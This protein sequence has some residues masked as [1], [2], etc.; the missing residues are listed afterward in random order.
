MATLEREDIQGIILSA[1]AHLPCAGYLLFRIDDPARAR[2]W[3]ARI[4]DEIT[5]AVAKQDLY[6]LNLA[7]TYEGLRALGLDATALDTF[8]IPFREGMHSDK[9]SLI[10]G[11]TN[12]NHPSQWKWGNEQ[13]S[14][15]LLLM[16][17]AE[18][19]AAL[20]AQLKQRTDEIEAS[21]ALSMIEFLPAGRQPDSHEHFGYADGIGQPVI[22]ENE[23]HEKKQRARTGHATV[24]K[25]GEFILGYVNEYGIPSVSPVVAAALDPRAQLPEYKVPEDLRFAREDPNQKLH[26]LGYNGSYLV[27]RHLRQNV[28]DFWNFLDEAT[29]DSN[30][31]SDQQA[32]ERLG[33][34]F[35][36]RWPSGAPLVKSPAADDAEFKDENNFGFAETDRYGFA[37][38]IGSH[39]RRC[40][41]RDSLGDN[42]DSARTAANRHRLMRRGRS[43]GHRIADK[44]VDDEQDR[45][46][47]FICLNSDI[48]R[49]FE[50]VQQTWINNPVF[51]GLDNETDPIVG[52]QDPQHCSGMMTVQ[53]DP[54][55]QRIPNLHSF[56]TVKGGAYFFLPGIKAIRY[57]ANL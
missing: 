52:N 10:L 55:R 45:G 46:L 29:R 27:F 40:N 38:P 31:R 43:Y 48:E 17:F 1:Y 28:A 47:Y 13:R 12:E 54:L 49:Q 56:V 5:I 7:L 19:E 8:P 18:D 6:S 21:R 36:G 44:M 20:E 41:P 57:L 23:H 37:C 2:Q 53:D 16:V 26:S 11:D 15:H 3:L 25:A 24:I 32:R 42:P 50:F 4:A 39:I 22:E 33:A 35:V 51:G 14:V 34:K 9:R 30:N